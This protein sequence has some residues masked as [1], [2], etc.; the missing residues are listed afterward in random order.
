MTT[1]KPPKAGP[2]RPRTLPEGTT[3]SDRAR[4]AERALKAAGGHR[5]NLELN[6]TAWQALQ[7][8]A[9]PRK[10]AAYI[11]RLILAALRKADAKAG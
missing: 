8:L 5:M 4:M 11:E 3:A 6:A 7:R 1:P 10:R 9:P 2:G